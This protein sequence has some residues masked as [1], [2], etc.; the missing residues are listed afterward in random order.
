MPNGGGLSVII[1]P[2]GTNLAPFIGVRTI[3]IPGSGAYYDPIDYPRGKAYVAGASSGSGAAF[4]QMVQDQNST[5]FVGFIL[6]SGG[7]IFLDDPVWIQYSTLCIIGEG[8]DV[9]IVDGSYVANSGQ[10]SFSTLGLTNTQHL[11]FANWTLS[12]SLA[13]APAAAVVA[14][15]PGAGFSTT[16]ATTTVTTS[17]TTI[18]LAASSSFSGTQYIMVQNE[19]MK[20]V[21][22]AG[23]TTLTVTRAQLGTTAATHNIGQTVSGGVFQY[24]HGT[25]GATPATLPGLI[26]SNPADWTGSG[27]LLAQYYSGSLHA[28]NLLGNSSG[29]SVNMAQ[30]TQ[31]EVNLQDQIYFFY[32]AGTPVITYQY[33]NALLNLTTKNYQTGQ[34]TGSLFLIDAF[35]WNSTTNIGVIRATMTVGAAACFN[36][37]EDAILRHSRMLSG[38]GILWNVYG[39]ASTF[40][41]GKYT[42]IGSSGTGVALIRV[43]GSD[44]TW[45]PEQAGAHEL[46]IVAMMNNGYQPYGGGTMNAVGNVSVNIVGGTWFGGGIPAGTASTAWF[47]DTLNG[48]GIA[49]CMFNFVS[50]NFLAPSNPAGGNTPI[51]YYA[52]ASVSGWISVGSSGSTNANLVTNSVGPTVTATPGSFYLNRNG[53]ISQVLNGNILAG[54]A[55]GN[56]AVFAIAGPINLNTTSTAVVS[57]AAPIFGYYRITVGVHCKVSSTPVVTVTYKDQ[58]DASG[59]TWT[60]PLGAMVAPA[61]LGGAAVFSVGAGTALAVQ[62]TNAGGLGDTYVT[63]MIEYV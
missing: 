25:T 47:G 6:S 41:G 50:P 22:G 46:D 7:P 40:D 12:G 19:V 23:T 29:T 45:T 10:E 1:P 32:S 42:H 43:V 4:N 2:D 9:S 34:E 30:Y 16:I 35:S 59:A 38:N 55:L 61:S 48:A 60:V 27:A 36:G 14:G 51:F 52:P 5:P 62:G 58:S 63:A 53:T 15:S 24:T 11:W 49:G 20:I 3:G 26:L 17:A 28:F 54:N 33:S 56:P 18:T 37:C 31:I 13:N 8:Q 44:F 21:S 57:L 39:G